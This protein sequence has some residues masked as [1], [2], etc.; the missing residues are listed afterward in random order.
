MTTRPPPQPT[1]SQSSSYQQPYYTAESSD[2]LYT[3][4]FAPSHYTSAKSR[5]QT[6]DDDDDDEHAEEGLSLHSVDSRDD[7]LTFQR[8]DSLVSTASFPFPPLPSPPSPSRSLDSSEESATFQLSSPF[9]RPQIARPPRARSRTRSRRLSAPGKENAAAQGAGAG[10]SQHV[11]LQSKTSTVG[12]PYAASSILASTSS[13]RSRNSN[14]NIDPQAQALA[15]LEKTNSRRSSS[16][17]D[18]DLSFDYHGSSIA[19]GSSRD[20]EGAAAGRTGAGEWVGIEMPDS[21]SQD[22]LAGPS[23]HDSGDL[24][25]TVVI[26]AASYKH[27]VPEKELVRSPSGRL[28]GTRKRVKSAIELRAAY[29][30]GERQLQAAQEPS[31]LA[32]LMDDLD[33]EEDGSLSKSQRTVKPSKSKAE[34]HDWVRRPSIESTLALSTAAVPVRHRMGSGFSF[35]ATDPISVPLP[36]SPASPTSGWDP[37]PPTRRSKHFPL[38]LKLADRRVRVG[39]PLASP[40]WSI[41]SIFGGRDKSPVI[42]QSND[43]TPVVDEFAVYQADDQH[44]AV[45]RQSSWANEFGRNA[46]QYIGMKRANY[47]PTSQNSPVSPL[48]EQ[49]SPTSDGGRTYA[50]S[51]HEALMIGEEEDLDGEDE[52]SANVGLGNSRRAQKARAGLAGL[53]LDFGDDDN[54]RDDDVAPLPPAKDHHFRPGHTTVPSLSISPPHDDETESTSE[55]SGDSA[56]RPTHSPTRR[57]SDSTTNSARQE[58]RARVM[59][60]YE[61]RPRPGSSTTTPPPRPVFGPTSGNLLVSKTVPR[62]RLP[63]QQSTASSRFSFTPA[64]LTLVKEQI[65]RAAGYDVVDTGAGTTTVDNRRMSVVSLKDYVTGGALDEI[66]PAKLLFLMGFMFG[67]WCWILGGWWMRS[68]DGEEWRTH[69][70]RCREEKCGCGRLMPRFSG[71]ATRRHHGGSTEAPLWRGVDKWVYFNRVA[72]IGSS[73]VV[74]ALVAVAI[75]AASY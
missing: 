59:A 29:L 21:T 24:N 63:H 60:A 37:E 22:S 61:G 32:I 17:V 13:L 1:P 33:A 39:S 62:A 42:P 3:G 27:N 43:G 9:P 20:L 4:S 30:D 8:N 35:N 64:P 49:T 71:A 55:E 36:D 14:A 53:G 74:V 25:R 50:T 46:L 58:A 31:A 16:D 18:L 45:S 52:L 6:D 7:D 2:S 75:W 41:S 66:V 28:L 65:L 11:R 19:S 40:A 47:T 34:A 72:A 48:F 56:D 23:G 67:P 26:P 69:G 54:E 73:T 68:Q 5:P 12:F 44:E 10:P 57:L 38:P 15:P 70:V 51:V